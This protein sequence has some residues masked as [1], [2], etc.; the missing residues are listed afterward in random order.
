LVNCGGNLFTKIVTVFG[1]KSF[2]LSIPEVRKLIFSPFWTGILQVLP[3]INP[4]SKGWWGNGEHISFW[5]DIC[6]GSTT[7]AYIFPHLYAKTKNLFA[8][9]ATIW[10]GGF[11]KL[12]LTQGISTIVRDKK[13]QLLQL[14]HNLVLNSGDNDSAIWQRNFV[15]LYTVKSAYDY[16]NFRGVRLRL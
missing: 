9:L 12:F 15:G 3:L 5:H 6:H 2:P 10:N 16:Q 13:I 7:I 4:V 14:L 8:S 11:S 1:R